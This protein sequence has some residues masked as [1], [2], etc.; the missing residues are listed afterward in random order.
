[1]AAAL[2]TL[3]K[4]CSLV[5]EAVGRADVVHAGVAGWPYPIGWLATAFA[6]LRGKALVVVVESAP[7]R[8]FDKSKSDLK[9]RIRT[10]LYEVLAGWSCRHADLALFTQSAYQGSLHKGGKGAAYVTPATWIH[11]DEVAT[12][13]EAQLRWKRKDHSTRASLVRR[14]P[15]GREGRSSIAGRIGRLDAQGLSFAC[16][17]IG[18]G[19][20]ESA[21]DRAAQTLHNVKVRRL[22]PVPYGAP[23]FELVDGYHALLV[24]SLS[25]EQ[26]RILFDAAAR[27]IPVIA[28]STDGIR[29]HVWDRA[30]GRL[31]RPGDAEKLASVVA[32]CV[33]E[34]ACF[35]QYGMAALSKVRTSTHE[36]MH[37]TRSQLLAKH[38]PSSAFLRSPARGRASIRA[39]RSTDVPARFDARG[40]SDFQAGDLDTFLRARYTTARG[41]RRESG[42]RSPGRSL[43]ACTAMTAAISHGSLPLPARGRQQLCSVFRQAPVV[44][45]VLRGAPAHHRRRESHGASSAGAPQRARGA[46]ASVLRS[47]ARAQWARVSSECMALVREIRGS[48]VQREAPVRLRSIDTGELEDRC[49]D[50]VFEPLASEDGSDCDVVAIGI[51]VTEYVQLRRLAQDR[52]HSFLQMSDERLRQVSEAAFVGTWALELATGLIFADSFLSGLVRALSWR[53]VPVAHFMAQ[54]HEPD[55]NA[56]WTRWSVC[57]WGARRHHERRVPHPDRRRARPLDRRPRQGGVG[58]RRRKPVRFVGTLVDVTARKQAEFERE[59]LLGERTAGTRRSSTGATPA[60]RAVHAGAGGG[61]RVARARDRVRACKSALPEDDRKN[62]GGGPLHAR[63]LFRVP[64]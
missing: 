25:D 15:P 21:I 35:R 16:D 58:R 22:A 11:A 52:A 29:P 46:G 6:R 7:W 34:P 39:V 8:G 62:R 45:V 37:A 33:K 1:M 40:A 59:L 19:E 53:P 57:C 30:T 3:P 47:A 42:P 5:F 38:F 36:A 54:I 23:F 20:L 63:D 10:D 26:P 14:P 41:L 64:R 2:R 12:D 61:G 18:T 27:A 60:V 49:F 32:Q 13:A 9:A 44:V 43:R 4:V 51:D 17:F 31:V 48:I 50:L 56:S 55:R 28:S 24:P